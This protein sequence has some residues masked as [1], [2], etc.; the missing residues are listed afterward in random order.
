[1]KM[2]ITVRHLWIFSLSKKDFWCGL[3]LG[4]FLR[5][6][7][8]LCVSPLRYILS[9]VILISIKWSLFLMWHEWG[10]GVPSLPLPPSLGSSPS[11]SASSQGLCCWTSAQ[12]ISLLYVVMCVTIYKC[13]VLFLFKEKT[14]LMFLWSKELESYIVGYKFFSFFLFFWL[15]WKKF[16]IKW[17]PFWIQQF[18]HPPAVTLIFM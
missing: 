1:M 10:L 6:L 3:T 18:S 12:I 9:I 13:A 14:L 4:I 16:F 17:F 8:P 7:E 2:R 5:G 11:S 15:A